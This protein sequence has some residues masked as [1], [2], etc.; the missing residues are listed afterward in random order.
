MN[1]RRSGWRIFLLL[2]CVGATLGCARLGAVHHRSPFNDRT[3]KLSPKPAA[4]SFLVGGHLYGAPAKKKSVVPATTLLENIDRINRTEAH[5]F[6]ALGDTIRY[7]NAEQ[8]DNFE[9]LF[10]RRL[11]MPYF[12]VVGNHEMKRP[13]IYEP[14]YGATYFSFIYRGAAFI[15][16]DSDVDPGKI[17][18]AQKDFFVAA[19]D[20]AA[21][22][23]NVRNI[24]VFSH[25]LLW[26][27][28]NPDLKI[29]YDHLNSR[30]DY[31]PPGYY[32]NEIEPII[33][34]ISKKKPVYWMSGDIGCEWTLTLF[35]AEDRDRDITYMATGLGDTDRDLLVQVF[36]DESGKVTFTPIPLTDRNF[37][38]V[39]LYGPVYW[40]HHFEKKKQ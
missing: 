17:T 27:G 32:S 5:F 31:P 10:T 2:G 28:D 6:M 29:V 14:R 16:L 34:R 21:A 19:L 39:E 18:D 36:V 8:L 11:A 33:T 26:C 24:F 3:L 15:I 25:R 23:P 37:G 20:K 4:F 38:A 12:N 30:R 35:Y 9:Q 1:R 7:P 22:D 40:R 13:D